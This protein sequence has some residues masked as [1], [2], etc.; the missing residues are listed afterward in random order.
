MLPVA[1]PRTPLS[2][3]KPQLL[4]IFDFFSR[5]LILQATCIDAINPHLLLFTAYLATCNVAAP[6]RI[7]HGGAS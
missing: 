4:Q 5:F 6:P 7:D 1:T 3:I 2:P